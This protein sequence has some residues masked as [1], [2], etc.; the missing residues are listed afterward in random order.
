M[1]KPHIIKEDG[2]QEPFDADKLCYSLEESGA[3]PKLANQVCQAIAQKITPG[4]NTTQIYRQALG[5]LIRED[6][7]TSARYSLRRAVSALGPAGFLFEQFLEAVLQAHG[8]ETERNVIVQGRCITHEIDV[9][10]RK[11]AM[12]CY[13]EAKYRNEAGKKTHIDTVMYADARLIDIASHHKDQKFDEYHHQMWVITNTKFTD[14]A[15]QY[16]KCRRMRLI[17]WNY[18][19]QDNL[20]QMIVSHKLYPLTVLPTISPFERE[21]FAE[22]GLVLV[23]DLLPLGEEGLI[24]DIGIPP[25][26]AERVMSEAKELVHS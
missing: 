21:R 6:L 15:I 2:A 9:I 12:E 18:P 13:I 11:D 23:R 24:N 5:Y 14:K 1:S 22:K 19:G 17:G 16:G 26:I 8:Y 10:A 25:Q 3:S 4:A 20:A 7:E